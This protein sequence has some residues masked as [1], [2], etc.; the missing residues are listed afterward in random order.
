VLVT[1][2]AS[3]VVTFT[4][5]DLKF[6]SFETWIWYGGN[7]VRGQVN[8]TNPCSRTAPFAGAAA[9]SGEEDVVLPDFTGGSLPG[10]CAFP[11]CGAEVVFLVVFF[12][13][14]FIACFDGDPFV[15]ADETS[16]A[17]PAVPGSAATAAMT[18]ARSMQVVRIKMKMTFFTVHSPLTHV[19][20]AWLQ[21]R[22]TL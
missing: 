22:K 11:A 14:F 17:A 1:S 16:A 12:G 10:S 3:L 9:E 4:T 21:T 6:G 13:V 2:D 19:L 20:P 5:I 15:P 8:P 7:V 18:S